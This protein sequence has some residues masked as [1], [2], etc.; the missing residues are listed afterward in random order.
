MMRPAGAPR[1]Q[2]RGRS[3]L[4]N[5]DGRFESIRRE[6]LAEDLAYEGQEGSDGHVP[7]SPETIL[8]SERAR[9]ILTKNQ[10]P[11]VLF[12]QSLNPYRGCEHGCIYCYARPSHSY[13]G[14]SAGLDFETRIFH[15]ENAPELLAAELRRPNYKPRVTVV[16]ANTDAYQPAER[17]LQLTRSLLETFWEF[18]HPIHL[19]TKS[20][21][22]IRDLDILTKMARLNLVAVAVSLTSLR[23]D[24]ASTMEPRAAAPHR[25]LDTIRALSDADIP[26]QVMVA[27]VIP[28]LTDAELEMILESA[29]HAG[30]RRAAYVLLRLPHEIKDLFREWLRC[31]FPLQA[32]RV[33]HQIHAMRNGK[34]NDA[35][36][37][38]RM[39]GTGIR[40]DLLERRFAL[41]VRRLGLNRV[42]FGT[43][44]EHFR[45]PGKVVQQ[46]L[47]F[48]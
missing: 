45:V 43:T 14:L 11:D 46:E 15:K 40:A 37:G 4:S 31:H 7:I 28:G 36:F 22:V 34:D 5:P 18:R 32:D 21:L 42:G 29:A 23:P 19:I 33:L 6:A 27:P 8:R 47:P 24:I 41:A 20:A 12:D 25:R 26:V 10:S 13:I 9:T 44:A 48:L 30:A 35:R 2:R 3:A 38:S 17:Q 39:R 16:G 1:T